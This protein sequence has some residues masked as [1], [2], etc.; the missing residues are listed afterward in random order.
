MPDFFSKS[1]QQSLSKNRAEAQKWFRKE[2][3][4]RGVVSELESSFQGQ[5]LKHRHVEHSHSAQG[6]SVHG[7]DHALNDAFLEED[8][9]GPVPL[10]TTLQRLGVAS[11]LHL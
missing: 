4:P 10:P 8:Y 2:E 3:F 11:L 7:Y 1:Y 5:H 9:M 6:A